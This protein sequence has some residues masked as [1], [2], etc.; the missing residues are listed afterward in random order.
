MASQRMTSRSSRT[1]SRNRSATSPRMRRSRS[2]SSLIRRRRSPRRWWRRRSGSTGPAFDAL[3]ERRDEMETWKEWIEEAATAA[4]QEGRVFPGINSEA[5][6]KWAIGADTANMMDR[7]R[8]VLV[9][10]AEAVNAL[11]STMANDEG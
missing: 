5:D 10:K 7:E 1:A 2:R 9:A 11:I 8:D 3:T 6:A 4:A